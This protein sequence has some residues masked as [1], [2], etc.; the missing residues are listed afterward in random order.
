MRRNTTLDCAKGILIILVVLGHSLQY[1]FGSQYRQ[2]ELFYDDFLFKAIYTFH[3]PLFMFISG[4]FFYSSNLKCY[5]DVVLQ[6]AKYIGVPFFTYFTITYI[7]I[8]YL[9]NTDSF[10]LVDYIKRMRIEMW[11]LSSLLLNCLIVA[12]ITHTCSNRKIINTI[13]SIFVLFLHITS[14]NIIPATHKYMFFFFLFGYYW[15][16]NYHTFSFFLGK[17]HIIPLT[18]VF[19]TS[20]FFFDKEMYIY[21]SGICVIK[22]NHLSLIQI[23]VDIERYLIG[24]SNS[25]WFCSILFFISQKYPPH[26]ICL[27]LGN[28]T[29]AIYGLQSIVFILII[30]FF[31]QTHITIP[32]NYLSPIILTFLTILISILFIRISNRTKLGKVILL[33]KKL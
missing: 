29:L 32:H 17:K 11:F 22:E 13:F 9:A 26:N 5:K 23:A 12:T 14:D 30:Y 3:M 25:L 16:M 7:I 24:I 21:T 31:E 33:G 1:G 20:I 10:Y 4:F 18:I 27:Y 15:N 2:L 28:Y 19:I 8:C 6:K